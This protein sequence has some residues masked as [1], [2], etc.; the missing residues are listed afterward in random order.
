MKKK[1]VRK[2]SHY[3]VLKENRIEGEGE[4]HTIG[5]KYSQKPMLSYIVNSGLNTDDRITLS[6]ESSELA[7]ILAD[8]DDGFSRFKMETGKKMKVLS[9][10]S[11][12]I[13]YSENH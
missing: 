4:Y 13:N 1:I 2:N 11:V 5:S 6:R 9:S 3:M 12:E 7:D 8:C 10:I